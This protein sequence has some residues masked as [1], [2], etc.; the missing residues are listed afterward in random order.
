MKAHCSNKDKTG[1]TIDP[2]EKDK[3]SE[4]SYKLLESY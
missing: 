4:E 2:R 1:N 3:I